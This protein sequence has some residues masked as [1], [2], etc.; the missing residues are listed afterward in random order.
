M[1]QNIFIEI[2]NMISDNSLRTDKIGD[3]EAYNREAEND[4]PVQDFIDI[5]NE[6]NKSWDVILFSS[7]RERDRYRIEKWLDKHGV[8]YEELILRP[9]VGFNKDWKN[10]FIVDYYNGNLSNM[11]KKVQLVV[12]CDEI[13]FNSMKELGIKVLRC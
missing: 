12:T 2:E 13:M 3:Y 1:K 9:D 10:E 4:K 7:R 6:L 11:R 5:F 8:D